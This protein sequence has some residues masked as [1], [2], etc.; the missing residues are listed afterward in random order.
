MLQDA[1][2]AIFSGAL[3]IAEAVQALDRRQFTWSTVKL[4]YS[5][6]YLMR[7]T[8][9]LNG[10]CIVYSNKTPYTW[11]CS[12]GEMPK[13]RSGTTHKAA[14]DGFKTHLP[15]HVLISQTIGLDHPLDWLMARREAA[16]YK[17]LRFTEPDAP[18]HFKIVERFGTRRSVR[19]YIADQGHVFTFDP[20]HAMLSFPIA[21]MKEVLTTLSRVTGSGLASADSSFIARQC[22]DRTGPFP[23]FRT[24]L[25]VS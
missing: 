25:G 23:D 3:T 8:L 1:K 16:N 6:F 15:N 7:S 18:E 14:L 19:D 12:A 13:K 21:A 4:Y 10:T 24:L 9:A 22:Y 20:D 11:T 17:L 5:V 2:D